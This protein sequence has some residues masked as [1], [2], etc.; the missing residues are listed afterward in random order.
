M[1][2]GAVVEGPGVEHLGLGDHQFVPELGLVVGRGEAPPQRARRPEAPGRRTG[3]RR[4]CVTGA[5]PATF[6]LNR[7]GASATPGPPSPLCSLYAILGVLV[8]CP[9]QGPRTGRQGLDE[10]PPSSATQRR[11]PGVGRGVAYSP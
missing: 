4:R 3:W 7:T 10:D 2:L 5:D 11:S 9:W 8:A 6:S 1:V